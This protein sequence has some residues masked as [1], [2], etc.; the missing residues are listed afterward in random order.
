MSSDNAISKNRQSFLESFASLPKAWQSRLEGRTHYFT[1]GMK[2][3]EILSTDWESYGL[4]E[5]AVRMLKGAALFSETRGKPEALELF[6]NADLNEAG[7][8]HFLDILNWNGGYDTI[9]KLMPNLEPAD[10]EYITRKMESRSQS[11]FRGSTVTTAA[12][13]SAEV[14]KGGQGMEASMR[15][16]NTMVNWSAERQ[17]QF[18]NDYAAMTGEERHRVTGILAGGMGSHDLELG[19]AAM[20]ELLASPEAQ[21]VVG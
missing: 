17:K 2:Y 5:K 20:N 16:S 7:R 14:T 9:K 12:D 4:S 10:R 15:L 3:A 1:S 18:K 6:Q 21:E 8:R 11:Q 19:V 13:V